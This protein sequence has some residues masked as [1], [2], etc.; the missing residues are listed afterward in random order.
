MEMRETHTE[1]MREARGS[2][3]VQEFI[4]ER[5]DH[6]MHQ[7]Q[8]A[9]AQEVLREQGPDAVIEYLESDEADLLP[10]SLRHD[11][12]I[13]K[14]EMGSELL[15]KVE[16]AKT[17]DSPTVSDRI[18]RGDSHEMPSINE[19]SREAQISSRPSARELYEHS[20]GRKALEAPFSLIQIPINVLFKVVG[21]R[22]EGKSVMEL[23]TMTMSDR[24]GDWWEKSKSLIKE[25]WNFMFPK[26]TYTEG[27]RHANSTVVYLTRSGVATD[28]QYI[29]NT[30]I[31]IPK[32]LFGAV[33]SIPEVV[34]GTF[35]RH[36]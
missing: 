10:E 28:L 29:V 30:A 34:W 2:E 12:E 23:S 11:L 20:W 32:K 27:E 7:N 17:V 1:N 16:K 13:L 35:F 26:T 22:N 19:S 31:D 5:L 36:R 18:D 3:K 33:G 24:L 14:R 6:S 8:I 25:E 4:Q 9:H 15:S 21:G